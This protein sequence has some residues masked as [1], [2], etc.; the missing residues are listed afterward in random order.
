MFPL[1]NLARKGLRY[2]EPYWWKNIELF[3][4]WQGISHFAQA[5]GTYGGPHWTQA[6]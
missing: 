4:M 5:A 1:K 3:V 2:D 6:I